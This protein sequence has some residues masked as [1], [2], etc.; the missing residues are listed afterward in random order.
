M[1]NNN[2][3]W[4]KRKTGKMFNKQYFLAI[5]TVQEKTER[6]SFPFSF[7]FL[8]QFKYQFGYLG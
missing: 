8:S 2:K 7:L 4:R 5:K 1:N 6:F 3:R